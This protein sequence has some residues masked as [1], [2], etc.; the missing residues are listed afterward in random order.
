MTMSNGE[1]NLL[2]LLRAVKGQMISRWALRQYGVTDDMIQ[3]HSDR[4][5]VVV[6]NVERIRLSLIAHRCW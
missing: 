5:E 3:A 1:V 4:G 2:P 6:S